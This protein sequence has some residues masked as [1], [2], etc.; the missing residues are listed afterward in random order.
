M[1]SVTK[2][3]NLIFTEYKYNN[4]YLSKVRIHLDTTQHNEGYV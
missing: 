3:F 2:F 4:K 1:K